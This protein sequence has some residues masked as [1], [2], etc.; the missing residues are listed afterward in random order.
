MLCIFIVNV[1]IV[2]VVVEKLK[3]QNIEKGNIF[4]NSKHI[5]L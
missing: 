2:V 3:E 1:V 4:K 5:M